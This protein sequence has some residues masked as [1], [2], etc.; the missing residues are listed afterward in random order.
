[1]PADPQ[2]GP[3]RDT[4]LRRTEHWFIARGTP[5]LI[6]RY[7]P[8]RDVFT[9]AL[10]VLTLILLG[11]LL[12]ALNVEWTWWAN[13]LA[14]AGGFGLVTGIWLVVNVARGRP[15]FSLPKK[16]GQ[17]EL[18]VFVV[19]PALVPLVFGGQ[20]VA[21][22]VTLAANVGVVVVA[23]L[24]TSYAVLPLVRWAIGKTAHEV[25]AVVGLLARALPLLL[26][27]VA[28]LLFNAEVWQANATMGGLAYGVVLALF[29]VVGLGFLL[30]RLPTEIDQLAMFD[31]ADGITALVSE[32]PLAPY[33]HDWAPAAVGAQQL[34][35]RQRGNV[36]LVVLVSQGVQ[37]LIVSLM[38][39][40]FFVLLG[41]LAI[42]PEVIAAWTGHAEVGTLARG[43]VLGQELVMTAELLRVSGFLAAFSGLYFVVYVI[44]DATYRQEFFEEVVA[45]VRRTFAVRAVY[46]RML[47]E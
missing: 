47:Q 32:S 7:S 27:I 20:V 24:G 3:Q 36:M 41:L 33:V 10:P 18:G 14:V 5:H 4:V 9:R 30:T 42:D 34:G 31:D 6:E 12:N 43:E 35:R 8:T 46:L 29:V 40:G 19:A 44:T 16:V 23:Y 38:I 45:D 26:L 15:A 22:A 17:A 28:L 11:E 13:L 37:V 1:M 25:R 2:P 39:G 21:A